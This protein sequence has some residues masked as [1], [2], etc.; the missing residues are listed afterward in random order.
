MSQ[1]QE[2]RFR[3][4][5]YLAEV[6][7]DGQETGT[8]LPLVHA[9]DADGIGVAHAV[10]SALHESPVATPSSGPYMDARVTRV[11]IVPYVGGEIPAP[12]ATAGREVN[13]ISLTPAAGH[14]EWKVDAD[15][16]FLFVAHR[17]CFTAFRIVGTFVHNVGTW[18]DL[19]DAVQGARANAA[20]WA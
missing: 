6:G 18:F 15:M 9:R 13:G 2:R 20:L 17:G 8:E 12:L 1:G 10:G 14:W 5:A 4:T 7:A 16:T 3:V 11:E 19:P